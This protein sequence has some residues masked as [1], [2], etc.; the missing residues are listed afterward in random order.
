M[1]SVVGASSVSALKA[2][3]IQGRWLE[4]ERISGDV[5][6]QTDRSRDARVGD[7]LSAIGHSTV[8][9]QQSS[10]NFAIDTGIG[11][12][13]VA[14][15]TQMVVQQ[16]AT[17]SDG[18]RVTILDVTRGQVRL[19]VR[20]F[21][22]PNSRLELHTP[23]GVTAVRGTEFGVSVAED[24]KTSIATLEGQVEAIAQS[25]TVPVDAGFV[26]IV[27]PGEP[28]TTA[29]PLD[30]ELAVQWQAQERRGRQ[31]YVS[32]YIDAA[33]ALFWGDQEITISRTGYFEAVVFLNSAN[34]NAVFTVKNPLGEA[35]SHRIRSWQIVDLD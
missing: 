2:Q 28:P 1:T 4:V 5:T 13:A 11:S 34:Q 26:S 8:T 17:L 30:R 27:H 6:I 16:L 25:A 10:A 20:P 22:N 29:R 9:G 33:N 31:L 15:N 19:Q 21:S 23:T 24:G 12:L 3:A 18:A 7:R 32:G 35:R 14:Q